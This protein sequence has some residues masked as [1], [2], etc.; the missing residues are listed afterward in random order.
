MQLITQLY[1]QAL[2]RGVIEPDTEIDLPRSFSLVR[3]MEYQ[4]A[5]DRHPETIIA[6]WRGTCSGKHYTLK[7]IFAELGYQS[8]LIACTCIQDIDNSIL[9]PELHTLWQ[10]ADG[11]LVDVHNY[12]VLELPKGEMIVDATWP[13]DSQ[14]HGLKINAA[15]KPGQDQQIACEPLEKWVV[16]EGTDP[17]AFKDKL[18]RENFNPA[19]LAFR[20]AFIQA[21][22][23]WLSR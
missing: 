11:K 22:G 14:K 15:F 1:K 23:E 6:E 7:A 9:P 16:P 12:L 17:Q 21:L 4:R 3:D 13:L 8:E 20:E 18:L 5:S 19:E 10:A 2:K